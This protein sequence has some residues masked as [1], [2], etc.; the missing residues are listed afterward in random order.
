MDNDMGPMLDEFGHPMGPGGPGMGPGGPM[1]GPP[2]LDEF[3]HPMGPGGPGMGP[4][5]DGF[6]DPSEYL[7]PSESRSKLQLNYTAGHEVSAKNNMVKGFHE[8]LDFVSVKK[9]ESREE[10]YRKVKQALL[11]ECSSPEFDPESPHSPREFSPKR[12]DTPSPQSP[13]PAFLSNFGT[14]SASGSMQAARLLQRARSKDS[15]EEIFGASSQTMLTGSKVNASTAEPMNLEQSTESRYS[16]TTSS[17]LLDSATSS[18]VITKPHESTFYQSALELEQTNPKQATEQN[19]TS[20]P[21]FHHHQ[22]Q[23][24]HPSTSRNTNF[25]FADESF[26]VCL[27]S[28]ELDGAP[29]LHPSGSNRSHPAG[30]GPHLFGTIPEVPEEEEGSPTT[31]DGVSRA[32]RPGKPPHTTTKNLLLLFC[33]R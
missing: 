9:I 2:M 23:N 12:P 8:D 18:L 33:I 30:T 19:S 15:L 13:S 24:L 7:E 17:K 27:L 11:S 20:T 3:G 1:D 28:P 32:K 14:D 4:G 10:E 21:S 29:G 25:L 31:G 5:P 22:N 16:F 26:P 6:F